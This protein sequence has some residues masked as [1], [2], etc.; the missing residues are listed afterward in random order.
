MPRYH[1]RRWPKVTAAYAVFVIVLSAITAFAHEEVAEKDQATV[2]RLAIAVLVAIVVIHLRGFFRGDPLWDPPSEF[3]DAL[4]TETPAPK[5]D[6][7]FAKL[8]SEVAHSLASRSF[9]ENVLWPRLR[10]L[11]G[12]R[13][14]HDDPLLPA[15]LSWAA[16]RG[17]LRQALAA[18][19]D[20]IEDGQ[21]K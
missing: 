4:A 5:I 9:L 12:T 2:I 6:S 20:H 14:G 8:R 10:D 21:R 1:E 15:G 16:H 7:S 3:D 18:L 17:A 11:A 13:L 19:I